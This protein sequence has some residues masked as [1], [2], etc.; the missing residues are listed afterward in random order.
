MRACTRTFLIIPLLLAGLLLSGCANAY[1]KGKQQPK[2]PTGTDQLATVQQ[3][4]AQ[5]TKARSA[6]F[7]VVM[8]TSGTVEGAAGT[9]TAQ[10]A[11]DWVAN[12]GWS[13]ETSHEMGTT[14]TTR[15]ITIGATTWTGMPNPTQPVDTMPG[16]GKI[17]DAVAKQIA[18]DIANAQRAKPWT[19]ITLPKWMTTL[20]GSSPLMGF[21]AG[22][23]GGSD[24][25][26]G[27]AFLNAAQRVT[28]VGQ[29]QVRGVLTTRYRVTFDMAKVEE[30]ALAAA[31]KAGAPNLPDPATAQAEMRK[32]GLEAFPIDVWIDAQGRIRRMHYQMTMTIPDT[33]P[34]EPA[35][36]KGGRLTTD[37][38]I[39]LFDF[40]VPVH[41]SPPPA[42]QV[43]DMGDLTS[44]SGPSASGSDTTP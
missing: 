11:W 2:V 31:K 35:G 26:E 32:A 29:E 3:A 12:K 40:G 39:D 42:S 43:Q 9:T 28:T 34:G 44:S 21:G 16:S 23:G 33:I 38:T 13:E 4:A 15:T 22:I 1:I 7:Q 5:L 14:F 37:S 8:R 24:P 25:S 20:G 19:K 27:L 41:V 18:K 30:K 17:P 36:L 10:G 6:R